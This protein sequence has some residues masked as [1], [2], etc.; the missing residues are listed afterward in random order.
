[1][2]VPLPRLLPR[3][4]RHPEV[5][6]LV[7]DAD[8]PEALGALVVEIVTR[9]RLWR[10]ERADV[11]A[12]L[13]AH[14]RDGVEAGA[15]AAT[16]A[17]GFGD[18][19]LSAKLIGRAMRRKRPLAWRAGRRGLQGL[20]ACLGLLLAVYLYAALRFLG[21]TPAITRDYLA[22]LNAP[23]A[24]LAPQ[25]KAWPLYREAILALRDVDDPAREARPGFHGWTELTASVEAHAPALAMVREAAARPG[26]GYVAG[27]AI[28]EADRAVWPGIPVEA[29]A[30]PAGLISV[31]LPY[32]AEVQKLVRLLAADM[33]RAAA[34][35]DG[36]IA[37]GDFAAAIGMS[38]QV[39]VPSTLIGELVSLAVVSKALDTLS[40]VIALHPEA[41]TDAGLRRLAHEVAALH[42]DRLRVR[43]DGER[44]WFGDFL[45]RVYTDDGDGDGHVTAAGLDWLATGVVDVRPDAAAYLMAPAA[46]VVTAG[47]RD[48]GAMYERL[49]ARAEAEWSKPLWQQDAEAL[50]R[51]IEMLS[52]SPLNRVRYWPVLLLMPAYGRAGVQSEL[53][54]LRRD[55]VLVAIA[56]EL[57]RRRSGSW[58]ASLDA[59]VPDLLPAVPLDRYDGKPLRYRLVAGAPLLYSAGTDRDDDG[60][61][62]VAGTSTG[63]LLG[64]GDWILRAVP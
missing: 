16:I 3:R 40:E 8:L 21:G 61:R 27:F 38:R 20:A 13:L 54:A 34:A 12:E 2:P 53:A 52:A 45:Q 22:E 31:L 19:R 64:D 9:A 33:H 41:F 47:R 28:D 10:S 44:A 7:R 14:L 26:L 58:P 62:E 42:H 30:A 60:G 55:A 15:G 29:Q 46:A 24:A 32:L 39:R 63:P 4:P 37:A 43:L 23:A 36:E 18:V 56:L 50:D 1:M 25:E 35:G 6:D 17:A 51:E 57:Y 59:L 48:M 49:V 5:R 11:A